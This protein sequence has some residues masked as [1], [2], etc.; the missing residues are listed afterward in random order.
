MPS[1]LCL[2]PA[3]LNLVRPEL[4][5]LLRLAQGEFEQLLQ[6]GHSAGPAACRARLAQADGVLRLLELPD[7]ARLAS[8]LA[9]L[10]STAPAAGSRAAQGVL[11]GF[12]VLLRYLDHLA[13]CREAI[14]DLLI[15]EI[16]AIRLLLSRPPIGEASFASLEGLSPHEAPAPSG[17]ARP[18]PATVKRLRHMFQVGLLGLMKGRSDPVN[19]HL[20]QR[21]AQRMRTGRAGEQTWWLLDAVL[22]GISG[23]ELTLTPMRLRLL[24]RVDREFRAAQQDPLAAGETALHA[25]LL[26]LATKCA[27]SARCAAVRE[28]F[29]LPRPGLTDQAL[30]EERRLLLGASIAS[31]DSIARALRADVHA[32]KETL[33]NAAA[34]GGATPAVV[35]ELRDHLRRMSGVLRDGGLAALASTLDTQLERI[36]TQETSGLLPRAA[37]SGIAD[38]LLGV[39][40][41]LEGLGNTQALARRLREQSGEAGMGSA[42]VARQVLD[43]ARQMLL[44]SARESIEAA[45]SAVAAYVEGESEA[46]VLRPA[47]GSLAAVRGSLQMLEQPQAAGVVAAAVGVVEG[48]LSPGA[49]LGREAFGEGMAD[50]LICLEYHLAALAAGEAADPLM[51]KLAAESLAQLGAT[52]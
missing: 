31:I 47:L 49:S 41:T 38:A 23:G 1:R 3:S 11:H 32:L 10:V 9:E 43:E 48:S 51:L 50:V 5:Q 14:P 46:E 25:E 18:D 6:P 30:A 34:H 44:Q 52:P 26:F 40:A 4:L 7:G 12:F 15:E 13:G 20:L 21:A 37:L 29:G 8:E 24:G 45:K 19:H 35:A 33:E 42:G 39:E 2:N 28:A 17:A 36:A 27:R 16:N 22:E